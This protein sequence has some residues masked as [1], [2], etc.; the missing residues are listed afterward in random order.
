MLGSMSAATHFLIRLAGDLVVQG[1]IH[2]VTAALA[3]GCRLR[4]LADQASFAA[5]LG[6][7]E[8]TLRR[9]EA[10]ALSFDELP[11]AYLAYLDGVEPSVDLVGFRSLALQTDGLRGLA[12]PTSDAAAE[13]IRLDHR[14]SAS[15][16]HDIQ[17]VS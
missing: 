16:G 6:I 11:V 8:F 12:A 17:Y 4:T 9:A 14:R 15:R 3:R 10:G 5:V 7:D 13:V 2:P 1:L